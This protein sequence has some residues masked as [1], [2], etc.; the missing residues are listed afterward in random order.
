MVRRLLL[1][2]GFRLD[3]F[4]LLEV[5][6]ELLEALEGDL[7]LAGQPEALPQDLFV[8]GVHGAWSVARTHAEFLEDLLEVVDV[9]VVLA[10]FVEDAVDLGD[11][12][13]VCQ[14]VVFEQLVELGGFDLGLAV[15]ECGDLVFGEVRV[16]DLGE[17]RVRPSCSRAL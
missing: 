3:V 5:A 7:V 16:D 9:E 1:A 10:V 17:R 14:L 6:E 4:G 8:L 2:G 13:E 11:G 15:G 12:V